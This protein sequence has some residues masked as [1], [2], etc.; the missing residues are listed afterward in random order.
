MTC[1]LIDDYKAALA[2]HDKAIKA[3]E[4]VRDKY[5][6]LQIGDAEY[7]AAREL[8]VEAGKRFDEAY[9]LEA[10]RPSNEERVAR[11]G[12]DELVTIR[13]ASVLWR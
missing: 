2:A 10:A 11:W 9:D 13:P 7:L 1:D 5:R 4:I 3:Y 8:W 6:A 12:C